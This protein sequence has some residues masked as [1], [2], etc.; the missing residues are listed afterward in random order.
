MKMHNKGAKVQ[1][2]KKVMNDKNAFD[3]KMEDPVIDFGKN[4][5]TD[6]PIEHQNL[7]K[8]IQSDN[9][10]MKSIPLKPP[11]FFKPNTAFDTN[12]MF[13]ISKDSSK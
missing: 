6:I 9:T 11:M 13:T 2:P 3:L 8:K 1:M 7:F 12:N 10:P 4:Y 5:L